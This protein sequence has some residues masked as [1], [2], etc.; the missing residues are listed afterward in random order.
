[1]KLRFVFYA[2][3]VAVLAG[4]SVGPDYHRPPAT[5]S[6]PLPAAFSGTGPATNSPDWKVAE[7]S[8][9]IPRGEWWKMFD[10]PGLDDLESLAAT[11]VFEATLEM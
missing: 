3:A 4:C 2:S 6:Q 7:P 1:M 10:R 8:A 11:V 5:P 9:Q